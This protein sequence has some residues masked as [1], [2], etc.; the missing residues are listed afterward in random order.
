MSLHEIRKP[1]L[2]YFY[3]SE[4][5][6]ETPFYAAWQTK[7][8][9]DPEWAAE[10][11]VRVKVMRNRDNRLYLEMQPNLEELQKSELKVENVLRQ[12]E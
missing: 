9:Y 7:A 6:D 2:H 10:N 1:G 5:Q 11:P 12:E 4:S 8:E 3:G